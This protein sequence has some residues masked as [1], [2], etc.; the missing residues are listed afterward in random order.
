MFVGSTCLY[1]KAPQAPQYEYP[2]CLN[3]QG[4]HTA[5]VLRVLFYCGGGYGAMMALAG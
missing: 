5:T 4:K 3:S 1:A 2:A